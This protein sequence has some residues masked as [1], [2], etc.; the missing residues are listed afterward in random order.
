LI[1]FADLDVDVLDD[2]LRESSTLKLWDLIELESQQIDTFFD[3]L[4]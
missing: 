2:S 1:S 4:P 3:Q